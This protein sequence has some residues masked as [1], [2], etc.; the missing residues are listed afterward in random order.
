[1]PT[2][3]VNGIEL[4]YEITGSGETLL[5]LHGH[6]SSTRDWAYQVDYFAKKYQVITLDMRG[7][8]RS[9]KPKGPYSLR[10]FAEDTAAFL[11]KMEFA[12]AH[13]MGISMG[14]MVT[15]ELALGFPHLVKSLV[16]I[17]TYP[18]MRVE[19]WKERLMVWRRFLV[20]DLFGVR[21]MGMLLSK[22]LFIKPDQEELR[23]TF[24]EHWA[25]ND[26][27]AYRESL[28]AIIN[29]DVEARLGE[30]RC[31]VLVV[32]SDEDYLPLEEKRA[33]TIKL[34][35]GKLIVIEDARHAVTAEHPG[36]LNG[37]VDEFLTQISEARA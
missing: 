11:Q 30:I 29:W 15:L 18:E 16:L 9:S 35:K 26:R 31:P 27:R 7:C 37:A 20:L 13:V 17:N 12:P 2:L 34:P 24:V 14:G 3:P 22:I 28:K 5:L 1:M 6:G 36:Q 8:G 4:Y 21:R 19:T 25:K 10:M 23:R 32:A 33:Y